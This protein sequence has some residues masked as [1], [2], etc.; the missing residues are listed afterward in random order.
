MAFKVTDVAASFDFGEALTEM[1]DAVPCL[2]EELMAKL[3]VFAVR[4][5]SDSAEAL[6]PIVEECTSIELVEVFPRIILH[7]WQR[8]QPWMS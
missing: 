4:L 6:M 3:I 1:P 8:D 7:S 5:T 2:S